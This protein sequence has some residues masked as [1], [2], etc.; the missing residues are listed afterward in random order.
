MKYKTSNKIKKR[1]NLLKFK[2]SI[3]NY[4]KNKYNNNDIH[5]IHSIIKIK[6]GVKSEINGWKC[7][8]I[9]GAPHSRGYAHGQLLKKEIEDIRAM[10]EYSLYEDYGRPIETFIE[11]SNDFFKP[12]IKTNFPEFY[13]E[14]EGIAK[15]SGQSID[16]I[17]MWNCFVSLDYLYASLSQVLESRN[18]KA[19]N[20]K[21]EK[22]LDIH[23][24]GLK[25]WSY[26]SSQL[27]K[28]SGEGGGKNRNPQNPRNPSRMWKGAEDRCSAFIAVG[29]YTKDGKIVCAHNTFDN[30]ID[31][32][33]FNVVITIAPSSGHRM[34]FQSAPGYIFSGTDFFTCSSGIFGTETTLGGFNAYENKDPICCRIRQAMQYGN[35]LDDYVAHLTKNN[36]GDYASTWYLGD[37]NTNEIMRVELGLKYTPVERTKNGYFIGFNAAYDPRIRNLESVNSGYDDIRRHQGARRV[38]LEQLMREHKGEID[39]AVAKQIISD[40]YDVYLNKINLCSRTVCSHYELDDRAFM[41]QSD[42]PKPYAPRG[43]VDGKVITSGLARELKFMGIWGSS[44]GTP[45]YKD[46]F[47]ERNLQWE[48]LKP[49]LHDRISQ[50]WTTLSPLTPMLSSHRNR[51][52]KITRKRYTEAQKHRSTEDNA[53]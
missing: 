30:F 24:E 8:T 51:N 7:I 11:M 9:K 28:V 32:Q 38:R 31:G 13:E 10:L 18:D 14:M 16:F 4:M 20:E 42:R 5:S 12:Q 2:S 3:K 21:Y 50:P 23:I 37:T 45:F 40:H 44:C 22:L 26:G 6:N 17:A 33:Y 39:E 34:M 19:L 46:E 41:S 1:N 48:S 25:S 29:S 53:K 43:A 52:A 27:S 35:T 36:S 49:Y 15:G 47:C